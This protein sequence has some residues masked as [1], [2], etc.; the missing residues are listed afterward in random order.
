MNFT[1]LSAAW[2]AIILLLVITV[3]IFMGIEQDALL[4]LWIIF[5]MG[6]NS[7]DK[8]ELSAEISDLRCEL[9]KIRKER[10]RQ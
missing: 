5:L 9:F 3:P 2:L 10:Y 7:I 6:Q 4:F 8:A 1:I